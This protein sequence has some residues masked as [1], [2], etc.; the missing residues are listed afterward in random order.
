MPS[1]KCSLILASCRRKQKLGSVTT[2]TLVIHGASDNLAP[3][4]HA[5]DIADAISGARLVK[6]HGLTFGKIPTV[7]EAG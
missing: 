4:A 7:A 3:M 5:E 6:I 2:P 1:M